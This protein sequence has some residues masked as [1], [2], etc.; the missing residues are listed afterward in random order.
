MTSPLSNIE[1]QRYSRHLVLPGFGKDSQQK[2][3]DAKVLVIG[4]GGLGAPLL[5]YLVAAGVGNIGIV[6]FDSIELSN[7]Q[8]Q[9]LYNEADIHSP[10]LKIA[11]AR[12]KK[13]NPNI[14]FTPFEEKLTSSN[15]LDIIER[16]DVVADGSDN[17][18]TRYLVN[19][20]CFLAKKPLVYGSVHQFE[21]QVSVFNWEDE[22]GEIGPNYRDIFPSPPPPEIAPNCAEGGVLGVLPGIIGSFQALEVIKIITGIGKPLA[23]RLLLYDGLENQTRFINIKK[24]EHNPLSGNSP[25]IT[26][27]ID[28]DAFCKVDGKDSDSEISVEEFLALKEKNDAFLLIDIREPHEYQSGNINGISIPL[29]ELEERVD[30][31]PTDRE[32]VIHCKSGARGRKGLILLEDH[33]ITSVKNLSGGLLAYKEKLNLDLTII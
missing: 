9:V 32:I 27:L 11:I 20:A 22:K 18:P 5:Q 28:C 17:F 21:G 24:D 15:A 6:E 25:S 19:D 31:I 4:A 14:Q 7:L 30:E 26:E 23:G 10:K 16:F 1:I 2:L 29:S 33:G 12:L 13:Q 3:K 8:R